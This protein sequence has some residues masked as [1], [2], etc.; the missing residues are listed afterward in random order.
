MQNV[1]CILEKCSQAGHAFS[2][3]IF[4]ARARACCELWVAAD[5]CAYLY[6]HPLRTARSRTHSHHP[7]P[8][9]HPPLDGDRGDCCRQ[10]LPAPALPL[11]PDSTVAAIDK[12]GEGHTIDSQEHL[13]SRGAIDVSACIC[14]VL[15]LREI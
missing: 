4:Y 2:F 11:R 12:L 10:L 14:L 6:Q 7:T 15:S 13:P 1:L 5:A 3:A 8:T 9:P